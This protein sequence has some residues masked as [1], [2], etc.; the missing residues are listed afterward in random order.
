MRVLNS[1]DRRVDVRL[2][3]KLHTLERPDL[4]RVKHG[5]LGTQYLFLLPFTVQPLWH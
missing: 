3:V 1:L 5:V 2:S 4:A